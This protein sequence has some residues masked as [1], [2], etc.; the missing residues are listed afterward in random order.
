[1][2]M[3]A[4][5]ARLAAY[6][7]LLVMPEAS[8]MVECGDP[9]FGGVFHVPLLALCGERLPTVSSAVI[10]GDSVEELADA[11]EFSHPLIA[12]GSLSLQMAPAQLRAE[13]WDY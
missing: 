11:F 13:E 5:P 7:S 2:P 1:M 12:D 4:E 3:P 8:G 6:E 10:I 9:A